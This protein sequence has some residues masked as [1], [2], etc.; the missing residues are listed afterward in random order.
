MGILRNLITR[1]KE[2]FFKEG[3]EKLSE[4][5][6]PLFRYD[7]MTVDNELGSNPELAK[8][9]ERG[10]QRSPGFERLLEDFFGALYKENPVV[11]PEESIAEKYRANRKHIS[12]LMESED[13]G[14]LRERTKLNKANSIPSRRSWPRRSWLWLRRKLR[15]GRK[16]NA[17]RSSSSSC[18]MRP[19]WPSS[20]A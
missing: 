1:V 13:F 14:K 4:N 12:D 10:E 11:L 7:K 6:V 5:S 8:M 18:W 9:V 16:W 2:K 15:L 17:G 3:P 19:R 20:R